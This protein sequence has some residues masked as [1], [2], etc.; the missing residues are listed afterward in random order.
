MALSKDTLR[1]IWPKDFSTILREGK[2]VDGANFAPGTLVTRIGGLLV[3]TDTDS[4]LHKTLPC[5]MVWTDG[6]TRFDL[7]RYELDGSVRQEH[8]NLVG[9]FIAD[10]SAGLFT[11]TPDAGDVL[12]KSATAGKIDPLDETEWTTLFGDG[13]AADLLQF[14]VVG[15]CVGAAALAGAGFYLCH[16][17]LG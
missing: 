6:A 7:Q 17:D 3:A 4:A 16:F 11:A 13:S 1:P 2:S 14:Q 12:V 5:E 8:T 15:R 9:K 10:V